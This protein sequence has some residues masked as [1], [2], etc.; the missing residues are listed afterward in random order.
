MPNRIIKES[1]CTSDSVAQMTDFEFRLWIGLIVQADDAGRGDA[2]P[3]IIKG[4][5]FPLRET[6]TARQV[7][8]ALHGL[9]TK[10]IV[11]LYDV[12]GK[13]Y[14]VLPTWAAHQR[15]RDCRPK[16][17]E[18]PLE[19]VNSPQLAADCGN[20]PQVAASCR[21]LPQLAADCGLNPNPNPNPNPN[22]YICAEPCD[23]STPSAPPPVIDLPLVDGTDYGVTREFADEMAKLY[24]AVDVMQA[25]NA[26]RGWLI[27]NPSKR[28]TKSGIKRF[29]TS[30][31]AREQD[32]GGNRGKG[33][34]DKRNDASVFSGDGASYDIDE[35]ERLILSGEW[36]PPLTHDADGGTKGAD[37]K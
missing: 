7:E 19:N 6:V 10:G 2:R 27:C 18:P 5:V 13:P 4:S 31:L 11:S 36:T 28:K 3:A 34:S 30:W 26:M 12:G 37:K 14:F 20:A 21:R 29:V 35:V 17:P 8:Q 22:T 9:A 23:V 33:G 15:V 24:P 25:L 1:I 32:R 16:Y